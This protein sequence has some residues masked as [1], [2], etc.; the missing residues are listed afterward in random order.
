MKSVTETLIRFEQQETMLKNDFEK[1]LQDKT[2]SELIDQLNCPKEVLR[3][4]TSL[5]E[6]SAIEFSHCKA[7]PGLV[8][9]QNKMAGY[10][11]LPQVYPDH[12]EFHYQSCR[13]QQAKQKEDIYKKYMLLLHE[14]PSIKEAR[15]DLVYLNQKERLPIVQKLDDFIEHYSQ[16]PNQKGLYLH[17]SFG[18][19]KTYMITAMFHT[20]ALR[21][22]R[23]MIVFWPEC[24]RDLKSSFQD[25]FKPKYERI[26]K[27]PLLLID[28][29]GA[30]N[31]T[32]WGRDEILGPLLQY[33]MN[34]QLPTFFTSNLDLK[35]L[36]QHFSVTK[37]QV[38]IMKAK[39]I[40]E[41]IVHMC[42][43][44]CLISKDLRQ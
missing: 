17:G 41:R 26:K 9:C 14:S 8:A 42:D 43:V 6:E 4:Y 11:Y 23:S 39:R 27:I 20:M 7:C 1:A 38:D 35:S 30:E 33:R 40:M 5:L 19:G 44:Q 18:S 24:L 15:M 32:A 29:I 13:Y 3:K 36:E 31:T 2:V 21:K 16:N 28:D 37:E 22:V 25:D 34:E 10:A 12:L